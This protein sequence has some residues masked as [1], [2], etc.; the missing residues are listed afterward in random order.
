MSQQKGAIEL[1]RAVA[2]IRVGNRH[3]TD[4][5]DIDALAASIKRDGLLQPI[6]VTPDGFLVCGAR[7]LAAIKQLGWKTVNVWVR[8]GLSDRLGQLLAEQDDNVLHKPLSPLESAAL[9]R[10]L[11]ALLSQ[12]AARRQEA[13]RFN[14]QHRTGSDGDGNSPSPSVGALGTTREQAAAM[15]PGGVSYSTFDKIGYL[16]KISADPAQPEELRARAQA[17]LDRVESGGSVNPGYKRIRSE[18]DEQWTKRQT[19]LERLAQEAL[20]RARADLKGKRKKRTPGS[21]RASDGQVIQL[22][23]RAFVLTWNELTDWWEKYD[24]DQLAVE[25][26]DAQVEAF[27]AVLKGSNA[28]ADRLDAARE[29]SHAQDE[30]RSHL[31]A[32]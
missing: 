12:D 6:T 27:H 22:P 32:L 1:E 28:F 16:E 10:E 15:V 31:R 7:R 20:A 18:A 3:R 4:L 8:S 14:S 19:E 24:L 2:S 5:G 9:Y 29:Q 26:T 13:T 11:K 21:R 17:E 25:L 23:V 30:R